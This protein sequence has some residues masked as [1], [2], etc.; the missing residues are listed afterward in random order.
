MPGTDGDPDQTAHG[1]GRDTRQTDSV[2]QHRRH[3]ANSFAVGD[4]VLIHMPENS[5]RS[6]E[7]WYCQPHV[8]KNYRGGHIWFLEYHEVVA[9]EG[10]QLVFKEPIRMDIRS[11]D[12]WYA[13]RIRPCWL[14]C[15]NCGSWHAWPASSNRPRSI[16]VDVASRSDI[17]FS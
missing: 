11:Q 2:D 4:L 7:D 12:G 9:V 5:D 17:A 16:T 14:N 15:S 6:V 13:A 3:R 1:D 8:T 10:N